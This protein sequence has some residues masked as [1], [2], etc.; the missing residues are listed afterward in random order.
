MRKSIIWII[1]IIFITG[2]RLL[3]V[4]LTTPNPLE[5]DDTLNT[6]IAFATS[7]TALLKTLTPLSTIFPTSTLTPIVIPTITTTPTILST[8]T[9]L[10]YKLQSVSPVYIKNFNHPDK[11]CNWLGVAG[12]V[13]DV[14][15][16]PKANLVVVIKG[17]LGEKVINSATL[18]GIKEAK[19]YGPGGF[20]IILS[21]KVV[22][23]TKSLFIYVNDL[24]GNK[25][26]P[27]F[28]FDTFADCS[29]NLV[30]INFQ[31]V[32]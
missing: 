22:G 29:R 9:H 26:T 24:N 11:G 31:A 15:D 28:K 4:S 1:L 21:D 3:P 13:F 6:P 16:N 23:S 32:K 20:E 30:I 25:L 17:I 19:N 5:T 14:M 27:E 18:T 10:P 8:A 12:Q 7:T 2:C